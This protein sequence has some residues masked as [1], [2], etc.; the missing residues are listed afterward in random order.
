MPA[1]AMAAN[2]ALRLHRQPGGAWTATGAVHVHVQHGP[3]AAGWQWNNDVLEVRSDRYGVLPLYIAR[4]ANEVIVGT[5]LRAMVD[6]GV[7]RTLDDDAIAVFLR[8]AGFVGDDTVLR[9][10][11]RVAPGTTIRVSGQ[12]VSEN[13]GRPVVRPVSMSRSAAEQAYAELFHE[14]LREAAGD[15][16][17]DLQNGVVLLSGGRDSR[18]ILLGLLHIGHRPAHCVTIRTDSIDRSNNSEVAAR[19]AERAGIPHVLLD[20]PRNRWRAEVE[21]NV[22]TDLA[23]LEHFWMVGASKWARGRGVVLYDGLAGDVLS[24]SKF[25]NRERLAHF[26]SGDLEGFAN[27]QLAPEPAAGGVL[28]AAASKRWCRERAL[29][30]LTAELHTHSSAPNP[31][32]SYRFWN[33]TRRTIGPSSFGILASAASV[34]APFLHNNLYDLLTSLDPGIMLDARFHSAVIRKTYPLYA[35]IPYDTAERARNS[36][37]QASVAGAATMAGWA[38]HALRSSQFVNVPISLARIGASAARGHTSAVGG[39]ATLLAWL[40]DLEA[41]TQRRA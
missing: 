25:V 23:C 40:A 18:H 16:E 6:A 9:A 26:M 8:T 22:L 21:K 4:S 34:R 28:S 3:L 14:A 15:A 19:L 30:R 31:V 17:P 33:R 39:L 36:R 41:L 11:R 32:Q 13:G 1:P 24:E 29:A 10:V 27:A 5:S 20:L 37:A 7:D 2:S 38:S 12:E 35:D